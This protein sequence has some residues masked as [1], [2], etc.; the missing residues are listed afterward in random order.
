MADLEIEESA[1]CETRTLTVMDQ[2]YLRLNCTVPESTPPATVRWMY[3]QPSGVM[4]FIH[5]NRTFAMD[6][7][8]MTSPLLPFLLLRRNLVCLIRNIL[9]P[10]LL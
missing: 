10:R 9:F 7:D 4:G 3:R 1:P 2:T 5:E 6:D 8:G